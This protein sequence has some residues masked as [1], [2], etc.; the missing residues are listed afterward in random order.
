MAII[1]VLVSA[2]ILMPL[3][4]TYLRRKNLAA[5]RRGLATA[6]KKEAR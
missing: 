3:S 4:A 6:A 5:A 2:A 1:L